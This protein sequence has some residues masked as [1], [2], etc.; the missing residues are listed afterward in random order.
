MLDHHQS[1]VNLPE[2]FSIINPNRLEQRLGRFDRIGATHPI[3][4]ILFF[5]TYSYLQKS[6][7]HL[8]ES[9]YSVFNDS[10]ASLQ[11]LVSELENERATRMFKEGF[12]YFTNLSNE[13]TG[14]NGLMAKELKQLDESFDLEA[15]SKRLLIV[16]SLKYLLLSG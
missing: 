4:S 9:T 2:A 13:L 3:T 1:E 8:F 12:E 7:L 14:T 10:I 15:L 6:I 16:I 5:E 11:Y